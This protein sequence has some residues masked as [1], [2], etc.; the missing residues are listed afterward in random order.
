MYIHIVI[1]IYIY[2]HIYVYIE[3]LLGDD[4]G[5]EMEETK[6]DAEVQVEE[7]VH[8]IYKYVCLRSFKDIIIE[9]HLFRCLFMDPCM[10]IY[11]CIYLST[12]D[13]YMHLYVCTYI[14]V[15]M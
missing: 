14:Y 11:I 13:V 8:R 2:I 7:F 1:N 5:L 15:Y 12:G 4:V 3:E 10:C 9:F 6:S